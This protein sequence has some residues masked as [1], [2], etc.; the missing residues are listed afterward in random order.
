[1]HG[2]DPLLVIAHSFP[3]PKL[4]SLLTGSRERN[5]PISAVGPS[6]QCP[7][8]GGPRRPQIQLAENPPSLLILKHGQKHMARPN[9]SRGMTSRLLLSAHDRHSSPVGIAS[10]HPQISLS[11]LRRVGHKPFL[12]R[13]LGH[14]KTLT[15]GRPRRPRLPRLV[16]EVPNEMV[17]HVIQM[18]PNQ[19]SSRE[20]RQRIPRPPLNGGDQIIKPRNNTLTHPST[21]S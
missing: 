7:P 14:P 1:M 13:L 11:G 6:P 20:P 17:S 19:H 18:L 10:E 16:N 2:L 21:I 8:D 3:M 9:L 15:D 12:R 5:R 4:K